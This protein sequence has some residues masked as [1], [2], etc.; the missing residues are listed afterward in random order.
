[1]FISRQLIPVVPFA[2]VAIISISTNPSKV[3]L[4]R[5]VRITSVLRV[6]PLIINV[7]GLVPYASEKV[8]P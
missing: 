7:P 6:A 5:P 1:M 3:S 4:R 8:V 2:D